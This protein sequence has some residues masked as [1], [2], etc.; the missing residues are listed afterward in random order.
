M[1]GNTYYD[2]ALVQLAEAGNL[3][4]VFQAPYGSVKVGDQ[5]ET[6]DGKQG[7]VTA[8][9]HSSTSMEG[10]AFLA[11]CFGNPDL[12]RLKGKTEYHAFKY[13]PEKLDE[14]EERAS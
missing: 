11:A 13:K 4:G 7:T 9:T 14:P 6:M 10:Y 2:I 3:R 8:V 1:T 5:V 12:P